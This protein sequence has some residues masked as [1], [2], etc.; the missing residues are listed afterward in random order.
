MRYCPSFGLES[1]NNLKWRMQ[2]TIACDCKHTSGISFTLP[3]RSRDKT[4]HSV[5]QP[6]IDRPKA[7]KQATDEPKWSETYQVTGANNNRLNTFLH[8][9]HLHSQETPKIFPNWHTCSL[10]H[11]YIFY[12]NKKE[13]SLEPSQSCP[14][15]RVLV[16]LLIP[17]L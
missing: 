17:V 7:I 16:S 13:R 1:F 12:E 15:N 10:R 14:C 9:N 6:Q 5:C 4:K 11:D 2:S 3:S 8:P